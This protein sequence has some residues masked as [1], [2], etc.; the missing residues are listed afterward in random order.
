MLALTRSSPGALMLV[1]LAARG[2]T[3]PDM[4]RGAARQLQVGRVR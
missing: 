3:F 1:A 2:V 4:A